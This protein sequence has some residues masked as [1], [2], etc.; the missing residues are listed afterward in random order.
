[1]HDRDTEESANIRRFSRYQRLLHD[2]KDAETEAQAHGRLDWALRQPLAGR[3][4]RATDGARRA[5]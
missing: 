2:I 3:H 1:M 4:H 5:A